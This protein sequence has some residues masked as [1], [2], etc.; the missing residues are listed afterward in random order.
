MCVWNNIL[1]MCVLMILMKMTYS[2]INENI[3]IPVIV[4]ILMKV[5]SIIII[6]IIYCE[7]N[8]NTILFNGNVCGIGNVQCNIFENQWLMWND[9]WRRLLLKKLLMAIEN[10]WRKW[11]SNDD[12]DINYWYSIDSDI[13]DY[14]NEENRNIV[15][16]WQ[17][18]K[19]W[20]QWKR[21][22]N[23]IQWWY[24]YWLLVN[25]IIMSIDNIINDEMK[26]WKVIMYLL[27]II[28]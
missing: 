5:M 18:L 19:V 1:L 21:S 12:D 15:I 13:D 8:D 6:S 2:N 17:I 3:L 22:S 7:E 10:Q 20:W 24:W 25:I 4:M 27:V 16:Q 28:V 11:R 26:K 14:C 9:Y 23:D